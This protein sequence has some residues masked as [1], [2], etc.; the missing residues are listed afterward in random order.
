MQGPLINDWV[1]GQEQKLAN[2]IDHT[3]ANW[4]HKDNKTLWTKFETVFRAA[5]TDMSKKQNA[6]DQLL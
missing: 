3:K 4:V 1:D 6:Y 2:C 5:W